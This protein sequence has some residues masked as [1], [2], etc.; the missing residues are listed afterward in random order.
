[1]RKLKTAKG[2]DYTTWCLLDCD[3]S[4][5]QLIWAENQKTI[6]KIVFVR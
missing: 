6:Q 4:F 3:Y 2:E 5:L 1:M